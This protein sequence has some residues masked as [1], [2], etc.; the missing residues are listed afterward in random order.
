MNTELR[1][2]AAYPILLALGALDAAGYSLIA[3]TLPAIAGRTG[4]G[5]AAIGL[6]VAAFPAGI[7]VGFPLAGRSV[8]A[9]GTRPVLLASLALV[10]LGSS[11]FVAGGGFALLMVSRFIMGV[12]SGGLWIGVTFNTLERWPGQEYLCMSRVFAAYAV[13][14]MMGP[15]LGALGGIRAPFAAYLLL[16]IL[17]VPLTIAMPTTTGRSFASD[18]SALRLP[19]FWAASAGILFAVLALG[20]LEG[21][22]PLHFASRLGQ[23]EIGALYVGISLVVAASAAAAARLTPVVAVVG[24]T[25]LVTFGLGMAGATGAPLAWIAVLVL[26]GIG[27]GFGNTGSTGLLLEAVPT[28]RIVTAM[29]VWS[30]IGIV[31]YLLGPVAGGTVTQ[32]LGFSWLVLVPAIGGVLVLAVI[33]RA[34][35]APARPTGA[36]PRK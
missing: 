26:A 8:R 27:V 1:V 20:V 32:A 25:A 24:S 2:R 14:G 36:E 4:T 16:V 9:R 3:P 19:G 5:P 28:E 34:G 13:G 23:A 17:A 35:R 18:R 15:A 10:A 6:L 29:V 12:G 31:G 22:L 7:V 30:E 33:A 11:G 21:V